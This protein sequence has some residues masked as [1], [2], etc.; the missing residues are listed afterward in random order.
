MPEFDPWKR[1]TMRRVAEPWGQS[2][3]FVRVFR[4]DIKEALGL[5]RKVFPRIV[6][7][8][9]RFELQDEAA[10]DALVEPI[11]D[12]EIMGHDFPRWASLALSRSQS[13]VFISDKNDVQLR[14]LADTLKEL[15]NKR[16]RLRFLT[17][18]LVLIPLSL[19]TVANLAI[20]V[21]DLLPKPASTV[22][23]LTIS[24]VILAGAGYSWWALRKRHAIT[25]LTDSH[26]GFLS[27]NRDHII[28]ALI[29][30][31]FGAGLSAIVI[32]LTR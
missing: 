7:R 31:G 21:F 5:F 28:L 22:A 19:L 3:L 9:N 26:E 30:G 10:L 16:R 25:H 24:A 17:M 12:L 18:P 23:S 2:F 6:L 11:F 8:A 1:A 32:L 15:L 20:G 29:S 27:R 13:Q 14:G 4:R